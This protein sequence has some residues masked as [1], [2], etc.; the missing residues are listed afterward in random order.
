MR[1]HVLTLGLLAAS[2]SMGTARANETAKWELRPL[3]VP[4]ATVNAGDTLTLELLTERQFFTSAASRAGVHTDVHEIAGQVA[5]R[6][7]ASGEPIS[8]TAVRK[9]HV[10]LAGQAATIVLDMPGATI[11]ARA[12]PLQNGAAGDVISLR[13]E[14]DGG[15]IKGIVQSDGT[16]R[17]E[18]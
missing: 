1:A 3:P 5:R 15:V 10:A 2:L 4:R 12:V 14:S 11:T 6:T 16:V 8:R 7:L 13:N 18:R 17:V 9:P